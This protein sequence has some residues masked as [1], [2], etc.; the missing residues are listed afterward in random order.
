MQEK[1]DQQEQ[2]EQKR[3]GSPKK[4]KEKEKGKEKERKEAKRQKQKS[5]VD[6][7]DKYYGDGE[8]SHVYERPAFQQNSFAPPL[9]A[10]AGSRGYK[11]ETSSG[12]DSDDGI[13]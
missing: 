7:Q 6:K 12:D 5:S 2:R 3:K 1:Q 11:D 9:S 13:S 4:E 10:K 8:S